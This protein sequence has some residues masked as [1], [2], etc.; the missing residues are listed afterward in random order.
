MPQFHIDIYYII[1]LMIMEWGAAV[2]SFSFDIKLIIFDDL[3]RETKAS[4]NQIIIYQS[5]RL[6]IYWHQSEWD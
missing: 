6:Q 4:D 3:C 5:K 1:V 2:C